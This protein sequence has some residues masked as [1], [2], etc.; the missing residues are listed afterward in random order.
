MVN[1]LSS[2]RNGRTGG[3]EKVDSHSRPTTRVEARLLRPHLTRT[4]DD[5]ASAWRSAGLIDTMSHAYR[6]DLPVLLTAGGGDQTCP[7]HTIEALFE[8]LPGTRSY[9]YLKGTGH[10]YTT[11]FIPLATAWFRLYA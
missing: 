7:P 4:A 10:R 8:R 9:T 5:K 2:V 11:E 1:G 6:L 3:P